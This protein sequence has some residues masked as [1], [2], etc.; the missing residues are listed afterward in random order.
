M[1]ILNGLEATRRI[2]AEQPTPII[3]VTELF[4]AE[5]SLGMSA[6]EAGALAIVAK[7]RAISQ[8]ESRIA[9]EKLLQTLKLMSDV[10]LVKRRFP[11][12]TS[13]TSE[14]VQTPTLW[15][16]ET[17]RAIPKVIAIGTS[18]GGPSAL[19]KILKEL[20]PSFSVPIL[21]TQHIMPGFGQTFSNWLK[22]STGFNILYAPKEKSIVLNNK[23]II[24]APDNAHLMITSEGNLLYYRHDPVNGC[25]PS[26]DVMF[27]SVA[28]SFG[29]EAVG[30]L[31]TGMGRD[32][33]VGLKLMRDAG[34]LTIT[35][36]E[37]TS[38][39]FGMP[40]A[41]IEL[42]AAMQVLPL[43]QIPQLLISQQRVWKQK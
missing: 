36:D 14:Y 7:P 42:N 25:L 20:P 11:T 26:V 29:A 24:I 6:I 17:Y 18:T 40:K 19:L 5:L 28:R 27:E 1:P 34:A 43:E 33:A 12:S 16:A 8:P 32:G 39:V 35:Q 3:L 41:A 38:V 2:M 13:T 9:C 4:E 31:L 15:S 21:I 23:V 22:N 10:K 30:I 37:A